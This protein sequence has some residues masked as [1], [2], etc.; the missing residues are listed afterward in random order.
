MSYLGWIALD[1]DGTVTKEKYAIP[2]EVSLYLASLH[3]AGWG[4]VFLTGRSFSFAHVALSFLS[5]PYFFALQNGSLLLKMPEK[6]KLAERYIDASHLSLIEK[7]FEGLEGNFL[8]YA[9]MDRGDFCCTSPR[10]FSSRDLLHVDEILLREKNSCFAFDKEEISSSP[11]VKCFGPEASMKELMRRLSSHGLFHLTLIRDP[12]LKDAHLLLV[13]DKKASKGQALQTLLKIYPRGKGLIAAGDDEN[14]L[15][16]FEVADVKIAMEAA[17]ESL[18]K[19]ADYIAP[20]VEKQ[21]I[22][23]GLKKALQAFG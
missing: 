21:G 22:I 9:G 4:I 18:K 5:F 17:P 16:M 23:D 10:P 15:S 12:F 3:G 1:I 6:K 8:I 2:E 20:S 7:A 14:D 13:T 19:R 11:L